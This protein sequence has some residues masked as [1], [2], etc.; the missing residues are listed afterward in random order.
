MTALYI[1]R[2]AAVAPPD[3]DFREAPEEEEEEA[4]GNPGAPFLN[5]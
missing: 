1:A 4:K 2:A 5:L 3:P